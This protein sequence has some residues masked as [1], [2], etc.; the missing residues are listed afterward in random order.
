MVGPVEPSPCLGIMPVPRADQSPETTAEAVVE[1]A[2]EPTAYQRRVAALKAHRPGSLPVQYLGR[3]LKPHERVKAMAEVVH[4]QTAAE[5]LEALIGPN[6]RMDRGLARR[7]LDA[8][9]PKDRPLQLAVPNPR[10]PDSLE[11]AMDVI[12]DAW[13]EGRISPSEAETCM[14]LVNSRYRAVLRAKAGRA[15]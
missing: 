13:T 6:N 4:G 3:V 7:A 12:H 15:R 2:V 1:P 10:D 8:L 5:A 11:A 14:R 9:F